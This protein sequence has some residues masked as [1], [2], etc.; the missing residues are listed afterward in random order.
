L[1]TFDRNAVL[2]GTV[3]AESLPPSNHGRAVPDFAFNPLYRCGLL[4]KPFLDYESPHKIK[5]PGG[6]AFAVCLTHDVDRVTEVSCRHAVRHV[7]TTL[8]S[9]PPL[10]RTEQV[11]QIALAVRRFA[12]AV[13]RTGRPDALWCYER[14][15]DA[16]EHVGA[17][18]TFFFF[19]DNASLPHF[20][21]LSYSFDDIIRFRGQKT[22]VADLMR[23]LANG[24]WEVGLHASWHAANNTEELKAQK[25]RIEQVLGQPVMSTRQHWLRYDIQRTPSTHAAAR[26]RF[27]ST[28]GFNNNVGFRFGTCFP[29]T[30]TDLQTNLS[31][32][33]CEIPLIAQ[34][35]ALLNPHKGLRLDSDTAFSYMMQLAEEVMR[36][37]GVLTLS[38]HP[39]N[40]HPQRCPGWFDLYVRI[41]A[42][43]KARDPWFAT[44]RQVGE[45]WLKNTPLQQ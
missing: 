33:V 36:V 24:G 38:F 23:E 8:K 35:T 6:K 26:L 25:L 21:D 41:L 16:E 3:E 15:L 20:S 17:R 2:R 29:W 7:C 4:Y 31:L 42:E 34:D 12:L 37:G 32:P 22:T 5:W 14:W 45:H 1:T 44:I 9:Q 30:L 40:I 18:S 28:L 11:L 43:L 39:E 27:D 19:P 10:S 13:L